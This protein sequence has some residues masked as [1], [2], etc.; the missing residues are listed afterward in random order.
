MQVLD[1]AVYFSAVLTVAAYILG[2]F[3]QNRL[4][5]AWM[6]PVL[7]AVITVTAA[8]LILDMDYEVYRKN[9][10]VISYMLTPATVCLAVP[11]Y[12]H[13]SV[14]K[15]NYAA[16]L[17]GISAGVLTS[18]L[19]VLAAAYL[20]SLDFGIYV[21]FLPKSVTTSIG[22]G[23]SRELGGIVSVTAIV[24]VLTGIF[25]SVVSE[26]VFRL[27][28][29]TDPVAKGV[30]LGTSSHA[31]GIAKALQIGK[32]EGAVSGLA[33]VVAGLMTVGA[34]SVFELLYRA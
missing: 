1:E 25:G 6:P 16:I 3:V 8:I 34:A 31:C 15:K 5:V 23:I 29:I 18:G 30:A 2:K 33:T 20:F 11:L 26:A 27:F 7:T 22:I 9:T 17:A 19:C 10:E 12:D 4:H 21:S 13:L 24:I 32:T 28:K 14:L